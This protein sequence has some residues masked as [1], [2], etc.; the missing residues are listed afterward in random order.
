MDPPPGDSGV[1]QCFGS[2]QQD[3]ILEGEA[4]GVAGPAVRDEEARASLPAYLRRRQT[5]KPGHVAGGIGFHGERLTALYARFRFGALIGSALAAARLA[6]FRSSDPPDPFL[7]RL[8]FSASI[9]SMILACGA[10]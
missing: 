4:V 8:A 1:G 9:R 6:G 5:E 2:A 7:A 10:S 3:E